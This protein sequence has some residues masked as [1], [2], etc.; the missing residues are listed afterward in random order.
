MRAGKIV[1]PGLNLVC[2]ENLEK[3]FPPKCQRRRL[4][5]HRPRP[6]FFPL[7]S[8]S[9]LSS[10]SLETCTLEYECKGRMNA[11]FILC[12]NGSIVLSA[13]DSLPLLHRCTLPLCRVDSL[14][15]TGT[16]LTFRLLLPFDGLNG[17][18]QIIS[19]D[20]KVPRGKLPIQTFPRPCSLSLFDAG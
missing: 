1:K 16:S 20:E 15:G 2:L 9:T 18:R 13:A 4:S 3:Q 5:R 6:L 14:A 17:S 12:K 8:S 11:P 7:S 19:F 10:S